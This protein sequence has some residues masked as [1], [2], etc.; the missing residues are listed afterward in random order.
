MSLKN[1]KKFKDKSIISTGNECV[2]KIKDL[3]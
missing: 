2:K 1:V 3:Q